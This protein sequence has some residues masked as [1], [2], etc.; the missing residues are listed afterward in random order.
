MTLLARV[1]VGVLL[2][3]CYIKYHF[4]LSIFLP[5]GLIRLNSSIWPCQQNGP[6]KSKWEA[7]NLPPSV[8][9]SNSSIWPCQQNGPLKSKWQPQQEEYIKLSMWTNK[10]IIPWVFMKF[11]N[12]EIG[13]ENLKWSSILRSLSLMLDFQ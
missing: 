13:N 11:R 5:P 8:I 12:T 6:S 7:R 9:K 10:Q 2:N 4:Q 3:L 1:Y